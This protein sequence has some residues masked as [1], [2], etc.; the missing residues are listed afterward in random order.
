[1]SDTCDLCGQPLTDDIPTVRLVHPWALACA[2]HP[3]PDGRRPSPRKIMHT[4]PTDAHG[5]QTS[6]VEALI[7]RA[8]KL[9]PSELAALAATWTDAW[10][11]KDATSDAW[12]AAWDTVD[13]ARDAMSAAGYAAR[14]AV[15]AARS[16]AGYAAWTAR[17]T[18]GDGWCGRDAA[19]AATG[20]AALALATRSELARKHYLTLTGPWGEIVGPVHPD[21]DA[22]EAAR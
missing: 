21:D 11:A 8:G 14:D 1:M 13:A 3:I 6:A 15:A 22:Q 2:T 18:L 4:V 17:A 16:A 20:D 5:P 12:C 9:T 7:E 10:S 19:M